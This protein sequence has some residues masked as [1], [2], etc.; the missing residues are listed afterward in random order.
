MSTIFPTAEGRLRGYHRDQ[1]D[2]FLASARA[3]YDVD[4]SDTPTMTSSD[5]RRTSFDLARGGYAT[6]AV[7]AAL[8]RLEDA[9]ALRERER[10][11]A[12]QG[13]GEWLTAARETAQVLLN[14]LNRDP[15]HR[16]SRTNILAQ[17]YNI[18]D[19][20]TLADRLKEY[21][22]KGTPV[23]ADT[24]RTAVFRA[25]RGGYSES[26]VDLVLDAVTEVMLAV[27]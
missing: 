8:E 18:D 12:Q 23:S 2:A 25:Q 24:V 27:R 10:A 5:I 1:V 21:F 7:D 14:R 20:D 6:H 4:D 26:Q 11:L 22:E 17:G 3:A 19:V 16:F 13:K 15:G 9:F